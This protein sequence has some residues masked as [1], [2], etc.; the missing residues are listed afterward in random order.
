MKP[1]L[2]AAMLAAALAGCAQQPQPEEQA[3]GAIQTQDLPYR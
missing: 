2:A 3:S 1:F